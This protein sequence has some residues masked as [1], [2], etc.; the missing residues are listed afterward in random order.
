MKIIALL[1][2][3]NERDDWLDSGLR[4]LA[5]A[6]VDHVVAVD[7]AYALFPDAQ[8]Q[9]PPSNAETIQRVCDDLGMGCTIH[10]PTTVWQ[11]NEMEKRTHLFR[12]AEQ[13]AEPHV[14]WYLIWDADQKLGK[15]NNLKPRLEATHA[16]AADLFVIEPID[17]RDKDK[18]E[19]WPGTHIPKPQATTIRLMYRA[20]PGIYC[21][22]NHYTYRTPD[23]RNLWGNG[24]LDE[25]VPGLNLPDIHVLHKTKKRGV[26]RSGAAMR[27]YQERRKHRVEDTECYFCQGT[28]E[29]DDIAYGWEWVRM[30]G[31]WSLSS[32]LVP[33]CRPCRLKH[34][35]QRDK[36]LTMPCPECN[37]K[38][39]RRNPCRFC[40]SKGYKVLDPNWVESRLRPAIHRP[41][42]V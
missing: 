10:T 7:G 11:G 8:P 22:R 3:Y 5:K 26:R 13:V 34:G 29:G 31:G 4:S 38:T 40:K 23:G 14:D 19:Y 9:S 27:Y 15:C 20:I 36:P 24:A 28:A 32:A 25:L 17:P 6:P 16:D 37:G 1:C 35:T 30:E 21:H 2:W 12:L 18:L 33:A 41:L 39:S 42:P